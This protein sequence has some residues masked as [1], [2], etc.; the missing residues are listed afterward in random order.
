VSI[1]LYYAISEIFLLCP[2]K[3]LPI[4]A[5]VAPSG[6]AAYM[7]SDGLSTNAVFLAAVGTAAEYI[8]R[9]AY[10]DFG[11]CFVCPMF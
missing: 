10:V 11:Q 5:I 8:K 3:P 6:I 9:C 1:I 2:K 7:P 4:L